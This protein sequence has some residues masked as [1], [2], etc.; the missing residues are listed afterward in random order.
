MTQP[1][2]A[3]RRHRLR[4]GMV[5]IARADQVSGTQQAIVSWNPASSDRLLT[6]ACKPSTAPLCV[7]LLRGLI[8]GGFLAFIG[9]ASHLLAECEHLPE[10]ASDL[11]WFP[12]FSIRHRLLNRFYDSWGLPSS[13]A[14]WNAGVLL[15]FFQARLDAGC[16]AGGRV[17]PFPHHAQFCNRHRPCRSSGIQEAM[18]QGREPQQTAESFFQLNACET[19]ADPLPEAGAGDHTDAGLPSDLR[20]DLPEICLLQVHGQPPFLDHDMKPLRCPLLARVLCL[21]S[22]PLGPGA[23]AREEAEQT[24]YEADEPVSFGSVI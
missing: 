16:R 23:R 3:P 22:S 19:R 11:A 15:V 18:T 1:G 9:F 4:A 6:S 5:V 17:L 12:L 13:L 10:A 20:Q 21:P 14:D 2:R 8:R 24:G 7:A